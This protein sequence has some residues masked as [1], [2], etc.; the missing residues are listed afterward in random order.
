VYARAGAWRVCMWMSVAISGMTCGSWRVCMAR[1][2]VDE[3]CNQCM[4]MSVAISAYG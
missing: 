1:V 2:Y 3:R 4:W